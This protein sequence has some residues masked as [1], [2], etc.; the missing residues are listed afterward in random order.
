VCTN[1]KL[2]TKCWVAF[3]DWLDAI[4]GHFYVNNITILQLVRIAKINVCCDLEDPFRR[5]TM[6]AGV[7]VR[8]KDKCFPT[9]D[10]AGHDADR[11]STTVLF[12]L[13][14]QCVGRR[15]IAPIGQVD[16]ECDRLLTHAGLPSVIWFQFV[17]P[18][19]EVA[20]PRP[21]LT[22]KYQMHFASPRNSLAASSRWLK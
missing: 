17:E 6:F 10:L 2:T 19:R 3:I 9:D 12:L 4:F 15:R 7:S 13:Q 11:N 1:S 8:P 16:V 14:S 18:I 20:H 22:T 21:N 5:I